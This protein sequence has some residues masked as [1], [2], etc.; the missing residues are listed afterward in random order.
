MA[1]LN[2]R[3]WV[4]QERVLSPRILHFASNQIFWECQ[5]HSGCESYPLGLPSSM[6]DGLDV[7]DRAF[8][9][10]TLRCLLEK[11]EVEILTCSSGGDQS[12]VE[13][14]PG[15]RAATDMDGVYRYWD[16]IVQSYSSCGLTKPGDKLA[17]LSGLAQFVE[18][19]LKVQYLAGI[20]GQHLPEQLNW[21][22]N[23]DL[24]ACSRRAPEYRAPSWSWASI[25]GPILPRRPVNE[26]KCL[27]KVLGAMIF[28]TIVGQTGQVKNAYLKLRASILQLDGLVLRT[29]STLDLISFDGGRLRYHLTIQPDVSLPLGEVGCNIPLHCGEFEGSLWLM[30][31][32]QSIP[33]PWITS[34]VLKRMHGHTFRFQRIGHFEAKDVGV[35]QMF[36]STEVGD[37]DRRLEIHELLM[38]RSQ[39]SE[40]KQLKL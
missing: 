8:S 26:G 13:N 24:K 5:S 17:A 4:L 10:R 11:F 18:K 20:W 25:D 9:A 28:P 23:P 1:P 39:L 6:E 33:Q 3:A 22:I 34:L 30:P 37:H 27:I 29:G 32:T 40:T 35:C 12:V 7:L 38:L 31:I 19:R 21:H 15:S 16:R 14:Q 36:S 2:Q